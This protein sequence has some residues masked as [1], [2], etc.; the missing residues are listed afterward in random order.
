MY[1]YAY[2]RKDMCVWQWERERY[3]GEREIERERGWKPPMRSKLGV[4]WMVSN[5]DTG[6]CMRENMWLNVGIIGPKWV[7][8]SKIEY[9]LNDFQ[10]INQVQM[11][12]GRNYGC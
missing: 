12:K 11:L 4:F 8:C 2:V 9:L 1:V 7:L 10:H 5:Q 3:G 6:L